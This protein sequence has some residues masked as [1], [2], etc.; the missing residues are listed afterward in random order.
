MRSPFRNLPASSPSV[1]RR[2]RWKDRAAALEYRRPRKRICD[3]ILPS[4]AKIFQKVDHSLARLVR[5]AVFDIHSGIGSG[6]IGE[7][8]REDAFDCLEA[9]VIAG[10]F[11]V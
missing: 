1:L 3:V 6:E 11:G 9:L 2:A 4:R 8:H 10:S 5:L 7:R